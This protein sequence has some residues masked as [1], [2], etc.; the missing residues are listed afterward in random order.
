M[1]GE[2]L[3]A[4]VAANLLAAPATAEDEFRQATMTR[5]LLGQVFGPE[6]AAQM[7]PQPSRFPGMDVPVL[8]SVLRGVGGVGQVL[9]SATGQ[10][11]SAPRIPLGTYLNLAKFGQEQKAGEA[12]AGTFKNPQAIAL[13]R[14]K[15]YKAAIDVEMGGTSTATI[16]AWIQRRAGLD[17]NDPGQQ[18]EID[19]LTRQIN[20]AQDFAV[21]RS[22]ATGTATDQRRLD[23][24]RQFVPQLPIT[25]TSPMTQPPPQ[26]TGPPAGATMVPPGHLAVVMPDGTTRVVPN[27]QPGESISLGPSTGAAPGAGTAPA[28]GLTPS[29]AT[30]TSEGPVSA[31]YTRP[32]QANTPMDLAMRVKQ[33]DPRG[34]I[35]EEQGKEV[36][37][38]AAQYQAERHAM[39][40]DTDRRLSSDSQTVVAGLRTM[41]RQ[42]TSLMQDFTPGERA[43]F[44]G[45]ANYPLAR[46]QQVLG[47]DPNFTQRFLEF[48]ARLNLLQMAKTDIAGKQLTGIESALIERFLP[49]GTEWGGPSEFETNAQT[50]LK[51]IPQRINDRMTSA[52]PIRTPTTTP[53]T[54]PT[55][56]TMTTMPLSPAGEAY[57]QKFL[58]P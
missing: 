42:V 19:R 24:G 8:G 58:G 43:Q 52:L 17:P 41:E 38:L 25:P 6:Q 21:E 55:G 20:E 4:R 5:A 33:I 35:T 47:S 40:R 16:N 37:A 26:T 53:T 27:P 14:A 32:D 11:P 10:A 1:P 15:Q 49:Q 2:D 39:I 51:E 50:L 12:L 9:Q 56:T 18:R 46:L 44:V 36:N 34:P 45:I 54:A 28:P 13:A 23:R 57:R 7:V 3:I 48:R 31:T 29:G 30:I 22:A